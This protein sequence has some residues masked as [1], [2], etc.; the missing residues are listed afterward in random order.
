VTI[1][2]NVTS[3]GPNAFS[4]SYLT[5]HTYPGSVAETYAK[6][7][8]I[9]YELLPVNYVISITL[10]EPSLLMSP[11]DITSISAEFL[12]VDATIKAVN[13]TSSDTAV[14]MV[15]TD[16]QV[17]AVG[18]GSAT[19][20]ATAKDGGGASAICSV[21]VTQPVTSIT[22][23]PVSVALDTGGTRQLAATV[24][25]DNASDESIQWSSGNTAV[26]TV[27]NKGLVTAI[28]PGTTTITATALDGSG[29]SG[30]AEI[31]VNKLQYDMS[32]VAWNYSEAFTHDGTVKTVALS[33]L[34]ESVTPE[35]SGNAATEAGTYIASVTFT[36]DT[37]NYEAPIMPDLTWVIEP[38]ADPKLPGDAN[39]D[40]KIDILD[41][42]AIIDYIVSGTVPKS[43]E[44]A[45]ANGSG[46]GAVD[47][48][49]LVWVIDQI[50][51]G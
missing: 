7:N 17:M 3:I 15:T 24:S 30:S 4:Y 20:T 1:P 19:I 27:D 38:A 36:Y 14:A 43:L 6:A 12:P 51:G 33:G 31:T 28:A 48:L 37:V 32:G 49:D 44:N 8:S 10:D 46:D 18:L 26:A 21:N 45:N 39:A 42:V 11:G 47:I 16:G 22:I 40:G 50:V 9:P 34:P 29:V 35:Y 41:L 5:L 2:F 13:W 25:P 23:E